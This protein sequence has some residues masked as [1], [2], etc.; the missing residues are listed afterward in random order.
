MALWIGREYLRRK[1]E[2]SDAKADKRIAVLASPA[3]HYSLCKATNVTGLGE[4]SHEDCG[5]CVDELHNRATIKHYHK[6]QANG[7]GLHFV[8]C[9]ENGNIDVIALEDTIRALHNGKG[10]NRFIIFLNEGT[11]LTGAMDSTAE[12]GSLIRKLREE[13]KSQVDFYLHVD[14]AYGGF[15]YPFLMPAGQWAFKVPEVNSLT[16]DP[17]KM[18]QAP[19]ACG[20]FLCRKGFQGYIQRPTGYVQDQLDDTLCGS[21]SGAYAAACWT[22]I[23]SEGFINFQR[24][25]QQSVI[26][27]GKLH[28]ELSKIARIKLLPQQLNMVAFVLPSDLGHLELR[29]MEEYLI[30]PYRLMWNLMSL[31]PGNTDVHVNRIVRF[32]ITRNVKQEWLDESIKIIKKIVG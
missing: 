26:V 14:A 11:I 19:M 20:L 15:I 6:P 18:G 7:E 27:A 5:L 2:K 4:G 29:C 25:H 24:M 13:W 28:V 21:R 32:I 8:R 30:R 12:V 10:I 1:R 17:Y 22:V 16:A 31:D 9:H 3:S 23:K